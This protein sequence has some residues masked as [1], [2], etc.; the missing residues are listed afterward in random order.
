MTKL[1]GIFVQTFAMTSAD[2]PNEDTKTPKEIFERFFRE[3]SQKTLQEFLE[4]HTGEQ[5][6]CDFKKDWPELPCVAKHILGIANSGDG[7]LIVG[8]EEK[9]D[10]SSKL[11]G[12]ESFLD[13]AEF[14]DGV[15]WF[16]PVRLQSNVSVEDFKIRSKK[17]QVVFVNSDPIQLPYISTYAGKGIERNTIYFRRQGMTIEINDEELQQ[18][19]NRRLA[20]GYSSDREI[21]LRNHL[22][23]LKIL[24]SEL[25]KLKSL[26]FNQQIA[27]NL[28]LTG[29]E[30]YERF[31]SETIRIKCHKLQHLLINR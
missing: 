16:L 18:L 1:L 9:R 6:D 19:I 7:C 22:E 28:G 4:N 26:P 3:R 27:L 10:K 31:L 25:A 13:K 2:M 29:C 8:V 20:T 5:R 11:T 23:E 14:S 12:L 17:V 30:P 21:S 24:Y 15:Y